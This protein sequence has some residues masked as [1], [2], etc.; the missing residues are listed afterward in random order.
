[1]AQPDGFAAAGTSAENLNLAA[2]SAV[3]KANNGEE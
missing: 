1:M 2:M 3:A